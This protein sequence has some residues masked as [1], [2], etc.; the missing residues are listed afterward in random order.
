M[1]FYFELHS[2]STGKSFFNWDK[3][4]GVSAKLISRFQGQPQK[5]SN[6]FKWD[7]FSKTYYYCLKY[8]II[9]VTYK[10]IFF[11]QYNTFIDG[12]GQKN[13]TTMHCMTFKNEMTNAIADFM[14]SNN[15]NFTIE[16]RCNFLYPKKIKKILILSCNLVLKLINKLINL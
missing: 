3:S 14:I 16:I 6:P 13:F 7:T 8:Y 11:K 15:N 10:F 12:F 9:F 1:A 4:L 5:R 2:V